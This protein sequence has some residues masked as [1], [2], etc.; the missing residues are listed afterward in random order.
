[1]RLLLIEDETGLREGITAAARATGFALD[2]AADL[3][4]GRAL[5]R[6]HRYD[7]VIA[8]RMLPDGDGLDVVDD[9]WRVDSGV[10]VLILTA[11]DGLRDRVRGIERGADDYLTKPFAMSELLARVRMLVRRRG[12]IA[13]AVARVGDIEVDTGRR[14][15]RRG[16]VVLS[17]TAKEFAVIELLASRPGEVFSRDEIT[18]QC[19]DRLT[20]PMSNAVDVVVSQLRRKLGD[21]PVIRTVRGAGYSLEP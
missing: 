5:G 10:P 14:E 12:S 2:A 15:V 1:M 19:W 7:C 16:G 3:S 8:D 17:T 4:S 21:P 11:R 6:I 20:E 13:P 18:G 9:R